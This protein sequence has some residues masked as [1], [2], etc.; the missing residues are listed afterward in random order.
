M[1]SRLQAA[2]KYKPETVRVLFVAEAPPDAEDRYFFFENVMTSDWLWIALM[3]ALFPY[4]WQKTSSE[5]ERK[6]SWLRRFQGI[7]CWLI[8]AVKDPISGGE[9]ERI[10]RIRCA[11]ADLIS[12]IKEIRPEQIILIKP[13][14]HAALFHMLREGGFAVA[15]EDPLPFPASGHQTEF[16]LGLRRLINSGRLCIGQI[17]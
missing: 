7:G 11:S 17:Y 9:R 3:K 16:H 14:V 5:R 8:D 2:V 4:E 10:A 13:S 6:A 1:K 12:E 15:N